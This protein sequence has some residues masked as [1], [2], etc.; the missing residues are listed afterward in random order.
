M[1]NQKSES[2]RR[3]KNGKGV[4]QAKKHSPQSVIE[5]EMQEIIYAGN[6][7]A[8]FLFSSEGLPLA[9]ANRKTSDDHAEM[10]EISLILSEIEKTAKSV[11]DING[12]KEIVIEGLNKRRVVF[13]FFE[14]LGQATILAVVVNPRR[15]YRN[16]TNRLVR[17]I[18]NVMIDS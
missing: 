8:A 15:S 16:L 18:K 11:A 13:R 3:A 17:T 10:V 4:K 2:S 6:Y 14:L 7:E 5:K 1:N 12:L 9:Q